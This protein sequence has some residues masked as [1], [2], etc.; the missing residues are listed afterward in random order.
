MMRLHIINI[1]IY[2]THTEIGDK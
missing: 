2:A 1:K